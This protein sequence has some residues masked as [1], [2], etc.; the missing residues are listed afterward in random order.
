MVNKDKHQTT[1]KVTV[2][3]SKAMAKDLKDQP[4]KTSKEEFTNEG[5]A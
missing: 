4:E 1:S 5:R 3:R 2:I